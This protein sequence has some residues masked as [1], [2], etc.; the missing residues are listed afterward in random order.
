[1]EVGNVALTCQQRIFC[2]VL[3]FFFLNFFLGFKPYNVEIKVIWW[4]PD[5]GYS[6]N[7]VLKSSENVYFC[8]FY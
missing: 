4:W 3:N 1:M 7:R 6:Q 5:T 8:E 2:E